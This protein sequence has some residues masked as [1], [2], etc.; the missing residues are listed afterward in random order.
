LVTLYSKT[1]QRASEI[2]GGQE[3]LALRLKVTPSHLALWICGV[4]VPHGDVFLLAA[5]I[6]S[7]H[8][9]EQIKNLPARA[10]GDPA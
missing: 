8:E 4:E 9:L 6:V 5:D 10:S 2:A 7:E 3:A 1:L